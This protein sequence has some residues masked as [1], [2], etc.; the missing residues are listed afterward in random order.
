MHGPTGN[1]WR[2]SSK[3]D[4][5]DWE[6]ERSFGA[7]LLAGNC[8]AI[9]STHSSSSRL[10]IDWFLVSAAGQRRGGEQVSCYVVM[11]LG[12]L[13]PLWKTVDFLD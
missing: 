4:Q 6:G 10:L 9:G 5:S 1:G 13:L 12:F 11:V 8:W 7:K 2:L 3:C